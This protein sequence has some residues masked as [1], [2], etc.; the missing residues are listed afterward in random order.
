MQYGIGQQIGVEVIQDSRQA[1]R[2]VRRVA[3]KWGRPTWRRIDKWGDDGDVI[4][5]RRLGRYVVELVAVPVRGY[6]ITYIQFHAGL[7]GNDRRD[8]GY[9]GDLHD[10]TELVDL[11][12][13]VAQRAEFG[14]DAGVLG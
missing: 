10:L 1:R 13:D 8:T 14:S 2:D 5:R 6:D 9:G 3:K 7:I 4:I 11:F 12:G